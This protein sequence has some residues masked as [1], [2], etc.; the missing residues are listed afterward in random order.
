[1]PSR[2]LSFNTP[3]TV[4]QTTYPTSRILTSIPLKVFGCLAF[5][6]NLDPHR[7]KLDPKYIKSIFLGYSPHQKGYKCYSPTTRKFYHTMDVTFFKH[8]PYY[9]K[10]GIQGEKMPVLTDITET[11]CQLLDSEKDEAA[12]LET[13]EIAPAEP[14]IEEPVPTVPTETALAEPEEAQPRSQDQN[15]RVYARK[16][17]N[18]KAV[19][20]ITVPM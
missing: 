4:L 8:Q 2:V 11:E 13:E 3:H 19:E 20:P 1:M 10:V 17:R 18:Q 15:W 12:P 6:H 14:E 5:V 16:R 9:P 7:S